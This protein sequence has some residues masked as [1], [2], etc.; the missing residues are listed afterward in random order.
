MSAASANSPHSLDNLFP[1]HLFA[2]A[3]DTGAGSVSVLFAEEF[4]LVKDAI[5]KRQ[6]EFAAGRALAR[7]AM[8]QLGMSSGC[9]LRDAKGAPLW[10]EGSIG[11][12]SHSQ[13]LVVAVLAE[14]QRVK[15][16]GVDV[17]CRVRR[18]PWQALHTITVPGER[19]WLSTLPVHC[20]E[21]AA[22]CLFSAKESVIKCL[23]SLGL[24]LLYFTQ[25]C[26]QPDLALG[27][28]SVTGI[29][30]WSPHNVSLNGRLGWNQH[31]VFTGAWCLETI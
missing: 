27:H 9:I 25:F 21:I 31:Y 24:P 19:A 23:Y 15:G 6:Q 26:V 17:E 11:S 4:N 28:F 20:R 8:T 10:C 18:F 16:V 5:P 3:C 30:A 1:P 12:I 14:R 29:E 13:N 7:Q 22:Y 2:L